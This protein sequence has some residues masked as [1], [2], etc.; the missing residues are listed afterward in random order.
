M[1]RIYNRDCMEAMQDMKDNEYDLAD[2]DWETQQ[3]NP[4]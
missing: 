2:R 4:A 3:Y 1:V